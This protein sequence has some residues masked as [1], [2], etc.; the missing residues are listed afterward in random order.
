MKKIS[1][2][3]IFLSVIMLSVS[4]KKSN[5]SDS[6]GSYYFKAKFDGSSKNLI[7]L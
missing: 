6:T 7:L 1:W 4:C 2:T 5:D 3:L